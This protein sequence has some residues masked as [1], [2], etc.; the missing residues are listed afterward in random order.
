MKMK[1]GLDRDIRKVKQRGFRRHVKLA[2]KG[3]EFEELPDSPRK[4]EIIEK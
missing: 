1:L 2:I 3:G 4:S